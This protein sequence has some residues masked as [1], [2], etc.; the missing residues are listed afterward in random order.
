MENKNT[1]L[2]QRLLSFALGAL[3]MVFVFPPTPAVEVDNMT[4]KQI[5]YEVLDL[6]EDEHFDIIAA[7]R[8]VVESS[9]EKSWF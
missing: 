8:S 2:L 7:K 3:C 1:P 5:A 6:L 4:R 9:V